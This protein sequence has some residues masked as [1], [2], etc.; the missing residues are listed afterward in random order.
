GVEF[1]AELGLEDI[2][3]EAQVPVLAIGLLGQV[4][5]A[6]ENTIG[7]IDAYGDQLGHIVAV[8][9]AQRRLGLAE[10]QVPNESGSDLIATTEFTQ[11]VGD[12]H[13]DS[14]FLPVG[15]PVIGVPEILRVQ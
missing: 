1:D 7:S 2:G 11:E 13:T 4:V 10:L 5:I 9:K 8:T 6:G 12:A 15:L 14:D 3:L